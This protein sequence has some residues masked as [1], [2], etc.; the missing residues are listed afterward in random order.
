M[1]LFGWKVHFILCVPGLFA[2]LVLL[3]ELY[4][5]DFLETFWKDKYGD[6]YIILLLLLFI[7]HVAYLN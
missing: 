2:F 7:S 4:F 3:V 1:I 6:E 5:E